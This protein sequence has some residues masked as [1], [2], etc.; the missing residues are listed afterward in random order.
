MT[1]IKQTARVISAAQDFVDTINSRPYWA[2]WLIRLAIGKHGA[3]DYLRLREQLREWHG[4][5][6]GPDS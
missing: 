5:E 6:G 4:T 2:R 3:T 1:W